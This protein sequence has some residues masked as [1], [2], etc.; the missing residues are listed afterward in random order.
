MGIKVTNFAKNDGLYVFPQNQEF[1]DFMFS[2]K[3]GA[4][5]SSQ[6]VVFNLSVE[7][8]QFVLVINGSFNSVATGQTFLEFINNN[9]NSLISSQSVFK[10]GALW[11]L[12]NY[13]SSGKVSD[14]F[15]PDISRAYFGDDFFEGS[16][17][18]ADY[19]N[20]YA[21][22]DKMSGF[23]FT[24]TGLD[25]FF[26]GDGIDTAVFPSA[27]KD[28]KVSVSNTVFDP[29]RQKGDLSGHKVRNTDKPDFGQVDL[30]QVERIQFSDSAIALDISGIAGQAYRIYKAAFNRT[31]DQS[32]LGY[33][34]GQ[35]DAGVGM[36]EV[37]ARFIDSPEF[38]ELYGQ[39]PSNA[40]FLTKVY[41]NVLDR[42]PDSVG[43]A[44]WVNEMTVNPAKTWQKVLADFSEST[45]NQADVASLISNG[46]E[47][48]PWVV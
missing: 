29:V 20:G 1:Y 34:I 25:I 15:T 26:G 9:Q 24:P 6:Q 36:V 8:H 43:L 33:W 4:T 37:A 48:V 21:G 39:N 7:N 22:N 38:R 35:M 44:W 18:A 12:E 32:G 10:D 17:Y 5:S 13:A 42:N 11:Q 47:Y 19:V 23:G 3:V 41:S 45:E 28:Y 40:E 30:Y 14:V 2:Q 46:I 31:P 27:R 16:L